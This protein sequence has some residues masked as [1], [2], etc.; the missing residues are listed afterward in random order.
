MSNEK[1]EVILKNELVQ[2]ELLKKADAIITK[3]YLSFLTE[4]DVLPLSD[5]KYETF[6]HTDMF[7]I[8][9]FVYDKNENNI[10]KLT[11]VYSAMA[12]IEANVVLMIISD[13]KTARFLIGVCDQHSKDESA[14]KTKAL[15]NNICGNFPGSIGMDLERNSDKP[16]LP[17]AIIR[18]TAFKN[19]NEAAFN[20]EYKAISSVSGIASYKN[21]DANANIEFSQGIEKMLEAMKGEAFTAVFLAKSISKQELAELKAEYELLYSN[22]T[23]LAKSTLTISESEADS[24]SKSISNGIS[25]SVGSNKS[26]ALSIGKSDTTSKAVTN[27]TTV[28]GNVGV[29]GVGFSVARTKALT[30]ATSFGKTESDTKT[31]GTNKNHTVTITN[32]DGTTSTYTLGKSWQLNYENKSI[33]AMLERI[34]DQLQRIK[35]FE[36]FGLFA[37][38][39]YFIA[40]DKNISRLA[41]SA[42]KSVICGEDSSVENAHI[43]TW[44]ENDKRTHNYNT[45]MEYVKRFQHPVF[46]H[47][48]EAIEDLLTPASIVSSQELAIQMGFPKKSYPGL[49]VIESA[50]FGRD[51]SSYD[52]VREGDLKLGQVFHLHNI[53][54]TSVELNKKSLSSHVF[55]TGST[56]AG[57]SNTV[58]KLIENAGEDVKFLIVE[59]AKGEYKDVFGGRKDVTV[60]GTNP[61]LSKLLKINPFSFPKN[62]LVS[63]HIDRLV[64][65][66][67]VCW[68]M[69]AAMP[70]ILKDAVIRAYE[71]AGWDITTSE[72]TINDNIFP[73]FKDVLAEIRLVLK[74]SEY[75]ADNKGDYTGALVTRLKSLVN[76]IYGQ[77]F[78]AE[79]TPVN[80]LFDENV[81]VDLSRVGSTE[82][83]SM[84]MG[85]LVMK[86]QEHRMSNS[87]P[88][89][90]NLKHITVLEEAHNLLKRTSTEQSSE[91]SNL[92]GKLVEM[93]A[94]SIAELRAFGEGF[95]IA[96]QSPGLLDMSVI[97][98]TNTKI[99]HRLPDFSD[100]ELVGKAATL[101][102]DQIKELAKLPLGVAAI[103]QND[104][105]NPV[106][107]KVDEFKDKSKLEYKPEE[108]SDKTKD[109]KQ[110]L[111][112]IVNYV[113]KPEEKISLDEEE[114]VLSSLSALTK[115]SFLK[116]MR[117]D[118]SLDSKAAVL[119]AVATESKNFEKIN[120]LK[121]YNKVDDIMSFVMSVLLEEIYEIDKQKLNALVLKGQADRDCEAYHLY[122]SYVENV[123]NR[124]GKLL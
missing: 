106:L 80:E 56:G 42:Y 48:T 17:Y 78:V 57:K 93:L 23:P 113:L 40:S 12:A 38:A 11:N 122:A 52:G 13:G 27:A 104:W 97:R 15:Y 96:D 43:N 95:V 66:F 89:N 50:E 5:E 30:D 22:L 35:K 73:T 24:V 82:T 60:Y 32:T 10:D 8:A 4:Y 29:K 121:T 46:I 58:F 90:S 62:I 59:P 54:D 19:I 85:L 92:I 49:S 112:Q 34:D 99:I 6:S 37:T 110:L 84:I 65:I 63:E 107:C 31:I 72:N 44:T 79:E 9:K 39:S 61:K 124:R 115:T 16:E 101:N 87:A 94:N 67:N 88:D 47:K 86:L 83:K 26:S 102:D 123:E 28:S 114:L 75:S 103:Y 91:S 53:E 36:S 118:K 25:D 55:I 98:N 7:E 109:S 117:G 69:Y 41:A 111:K 51:I 20:P 100:R 71:N 119:Y 81:I 105:I 21:D 18:K 77:I 64:E 33:S 70:A 116:Y 120:T 1:T 76:G 68:P 3:D 14:S 108:S 45:I 2:L 74:E